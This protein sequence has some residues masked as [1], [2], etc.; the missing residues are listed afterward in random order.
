M[1]GTL[2]TTCP[3][4]VRVRH[5]APTMFSESHSG[6]QQSRTRM[7]QRWLI[8]LTYQSLS[9]GDSAALQ[10]FAVS[11]RGRFDTFDMVVPGHE[12]PIG[13]GGGTP[14]VVGAVAAGLRS[15]PVDGCPVSTTGW[16]KAG[17]VVKFAGHTKV[18][19]LT[20]D[21]DSDGSGAATLTIEPGLRTALVDNDAV[22]T[23]AVPFRVRMTGDEVDWSWQSG[24]RSD[25]LLSMVE[26]L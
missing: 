1:S 14:Q 17:D 9:R 2:P 15:I 23:T 3:D 8:E 20:A 13:V 5:Q 21:A 12:T 10:A 18:Y 25:L 22:T 19:M 24:Y 26:A 11:Q 6:A 7:A 16:L 4:S